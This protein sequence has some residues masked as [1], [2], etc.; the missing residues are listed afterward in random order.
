MLT[1]SLW[2]LVNLDAPGVEECP[3]SRDL[4]LEDIQHALMN[5]TALDIPLDLPGHSQS[6]ERSVKLVTE[7]SQRVFG[8][9]Q[10]HRHINTVLSSRGARPMF[11]NKS[12]YEE[13]YDQCI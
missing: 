12:S 11:D 5:G 2:E 8:F 6:V 13:L 10:R 3:M 4:K 1:L 7:A 9:E